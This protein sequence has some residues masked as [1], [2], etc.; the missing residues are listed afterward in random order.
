M[1]KRKCTTC[2]EV[3]DITDFDKNS[4]YSLGYTTRCKV[5]R[6]RLQRERLEAQKAGVS[7]LKLHLDKYVKEQATIIL[8]NMGYI[9]DD[10]NN[11]VHK[12]FEERLK[13]RNIL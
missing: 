6:A 9:T 10:P 5:C 2:G 1:K 4:N 3:K 13:K 8:K 12:Q 11:P 7:Q